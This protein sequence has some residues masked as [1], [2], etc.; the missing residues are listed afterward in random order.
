M[1]IRNSYC[2][3]P[4][5]IRSKKNMP[6]KSAQYF[7]TQKSKLSTAK[8]F[9]GTAH[10]CCRRRIISGKFCSA[11]KSAFR[12]LVRR[13][14]TQSS[15]V[16]FSLQVN[17]FTKPASILWFELRTSNSGLRTPDYS[18]LYS[19]Q[20]PG[21]MQRIF[22]LFAA[23]LSCI[24]IPIVVGAQIER[25]PVQVG[26]LEQPQ[27]KVGVVL[28]A[29]G[30]SG[31]AHIGVLEALEENNIPIDYICGTSMGALVDRK[32]TRLNSS[33]HSLSYAVF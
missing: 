3:L 28:S 14:F 31:L 6:E 7:H 5:L 18:Y 21:L 27:E 32:S 25:A 4:N 8:C 12:S 22:F 15:I 13:A 9:P 26:P 10:A 30:T 1:L 23:F 19:P 24:F 29:G 2:F 17:L 20:T 11:D 16:V 33:H